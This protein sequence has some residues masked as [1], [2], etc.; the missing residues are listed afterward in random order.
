MTTT[1]RTPMPA[2]TPC[3]VPW[4]KPEP[5]PFCSDEF[6]T[7]WTRTHRK[8]LD[9][10]GCVVLTFYE[11]IEDGRAAVWSRP[12]DAGRIYFDL[13]LDD[14]QSISDGAELALEF[15]EG[16]QFAVAN[17]ANEDTPAIRVVLAERAVLEAVADWVDRDGRGIAV[18]NA[19]AELAAARAAAER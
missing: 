10:D 5:H 3:P 15:A 1:E 17:G 2:M 19:Y 14:A 8:R 12:G 7:S 9:P 16:V 4:C 11:L 18:E 13:V 6:E